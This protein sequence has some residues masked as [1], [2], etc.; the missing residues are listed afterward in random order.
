MRRLLLVAVGLAWA[1]GSEDPAGDSPPAVAPWGLSTDAGAAAP[2][3]DCDT[4]VV[5]A[6]DK[7]LRSEIFRSGS[8]HS[9]QAGTPRIDSVIAGAQRALD[10]VT[11]STAGNAALASLLTGRHVTEHGIVSLRDQGFQTL[12][13][14]ELSLGEGFKEAGW[15]TIFSSGSPLHAQG[16][17]GF[18]QGFEQ[19]EAPRLAEPTRAAPSVANGALLPLRQALAEER[20]VFAL[21]SFDDLAPRALRPPSAEIAAPFVSAWLRPV[22]QE[23]ADIEAALRTLDAD[24]KQG[25]DDLTKLLARARG[26][27]ASVAWNMAL[28]AAHLSVIDGA[29]GEVLDALEEAGRAEDAL[30]VFTG[31]RGTLPP[32][33]RHEAGS[34]FISDAITV[35]LAIRWPMGAKRAEPIESTLSLLDVPHALASVGGFGLKP[36]EFGCF[37]IGGVEPSAGAAYVADSQRKLLAAVH[38]DRQIERYIDGQVVAFDRAGQ[39]LRGPGPDQ[40]GALAHGLGGFVEAATAI[41]LTVTVPEGELAADLQ[42]A[43]ETAPGPGTLAPTDRAADRPRAAVRGRFQ[44]ED[45]SQTLALAERGTAVRLRLESLSESAVGPGLIRMGDERG[46]DLPLMFTPMD[47]VTVPSADDEKPPEPRLRI[48]RSDGLWWTL[49]VDALDDSQKSAS[50]EVLV[51]VWPPREPTRELEVSAGGG[52]TQHAVPGRADLVRIVGEV[53]FTCRIKKLAKE[54]FAVACS[55]ADGFLPPTEMGFHG[56]RFAEAHAFQCVFSHRQNEASA[57][58]PSPDAALFTGPI[59]VDLKTGKLVGDGAFV[60]RT[61]VGPRPLEFI[62]PSISDLLELVRLVPGE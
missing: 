36:T 28:R 13:E 8:I 32:G 10:A 58:L 9:A 29:I 51:S 30:V 31:L 7:V 35:P 44:I 61:G 3:A 43:W 25:I 49:S 16:F 34:L 45:A 18:S 17:S 33:Y 12:S 60:H 23:R 39:Q 2:L 56:L 6:L 46:S 47:D 20:P 53:P 26:S 62:A 57:A 27:R 21:L 41:S 11:T 5:F 19:Y 52:V 24:P 48:E 1:C 54:D 4:V 15:S 40:G 22:A 42:F 55:V 37:D 14:S 38:G 50:A 59:D